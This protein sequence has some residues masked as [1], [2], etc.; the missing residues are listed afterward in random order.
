MEGQHM[1]GYGQW[2]TRLLHLHHLALISPWCTETPR[3]YLVAA[4]SEATA[5]VNRAVG[6]LAAV[7]TTEGNQRLAELGG[8]RK[9]EHSDLQT[10]R[11]AF[12]AFW[13][14]VTKIQRSVDG[15]R[16][17]EAV[18]FIEP[19]LKHAEGFASASDKLILSARALDCLPKEEEEEEE[20]QE[21]E[22]TREEGGVVSPK[23]APAVLSMP[24][25]PSASSLSRWIDARLYLLALSALLSAL[26]FKL[27]RKKKTKAKIN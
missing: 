15:L 7:K 27:L 1:T 25:P 10:A 13:H 8:G 18:A 6:R 11:D 16:M 3:G 20:E 14:L 19:L 12:I 22:G 23:A 5:V 4:L 17:D 21:Q 24:R 2:D 9:G 26:L